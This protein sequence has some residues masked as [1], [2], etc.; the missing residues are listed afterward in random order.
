MTKKK[1]AGDKY[2][3]VVAQWQRS[4]KPE[5]VWTCQQH[6]LEFYTIEESQKHTEE[7][8]HRIY[9]GRYETNVKG[10]NKIFTTEK[11]ALEYLKK[12]LSENE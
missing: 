3:Q 11:K 6:K 9:D 7:F 10:T 8:S 5:R 1:F 4:K 12:S 2:P